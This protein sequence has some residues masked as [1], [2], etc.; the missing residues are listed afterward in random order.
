MMTR[1]TSKPDNSCIREIEDDLGDEPRL[2]PWVFAVSETMTYE[3]KALGAVC[4]YHLASQNTGDWSGP[5]VDDMTRLIF[6]RRELGAPW[7]REAAFSLEDEYRRYHA[8]MPEYVNR[9]RWSSVELVRLLADDTGQQFLSVVQ[10]ALESVRA[11]GQMDE[12][13]FRCRWWADFCAGLREL[14]ATTNE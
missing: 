6:A 12:A 4:V 11:A 3:A 2:G 1:P 13:G 10:D 8:S 9:A 7:I 5:N 14:E